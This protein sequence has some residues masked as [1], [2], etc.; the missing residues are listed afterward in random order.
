MA[1]SLLSVLVLTS[2]LWAGPFRPKQKVILK[3]PSSYEKWVL[4]DTCTIAWLLATNEKYK[5]GIG[6]KIKA[7][8]V[9]VYVPNTQAVIQ[10]LDEDGYCGYVE[11]VPD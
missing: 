5:E 1:K 8:K 10:E 9:V 3:V 11:T 2:G 6:E 7:D 4:S